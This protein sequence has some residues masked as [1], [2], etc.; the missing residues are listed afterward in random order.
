ME[1]RK[2]KKILVTGASGY[3]GSHVVNHL[4]ENYSSD[5]MVYAHGLNSDNIDCRAT[6]VEGDVAEL[7]ECDDLYDK[8]G[9]PDVCIYLAWQDGFN[10][11]AESHM[12]NLYAHYLFLTRLIDGGT[13]QLVVAGS[14]R[15][16]G[17]CA[18]KVKEDLDV[19]AENFYVLSKKT[20]KRALEIYIR[21]KDVCLQWI[22]PF[23]VYGD[24]ALNHS[25]MSK[26]VTWE[27]EGRETFP[28]TMGEEQYDYIEV[29]ELAEQIIAIA[30][31]KEIDGVI[32]CCSGKPTKLKDKIEAFL[33]ENHMKIRPEYG[34]F[35]TRDY[36]SSVIYGDRTKLDKILKEQK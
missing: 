12:K 29:N 2:M 26:I 32:N 22:R 20:L 18:G 33:A 21:D 27:A 24:E 14:F 10:H 19:E 8:M 9:K 30:S 36:D 1:D 35:P 31:Q 3:I 15:E 25:I 13:S 23:T 5:Y 6:I 7:S 28:F 16:Y 11:N 17:S 34:A 4:C